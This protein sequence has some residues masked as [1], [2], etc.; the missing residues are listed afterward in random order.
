M[1]GIKLL[2]LNGPGLGDLSDFDGKNYGGLS[3]EG[4]QKE[5]SILCEQLGIQLD[6][7]QTDD[8]IEMFNFIAKDSEAYDALII[9]PV[10]YSRAASVEFEM[11]HSAILT[12]AHLKKPVIEVH[13]TNIFKP[14]AEITKPLQVPEGNMGFI[15]GLGISGY[16]LAIKA[17]NKRLNE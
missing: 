7:R 11:Y 9:N 16:L 5:C 13:I 14:E 3:L 15:S 2:I 6:F 4:I 12:I 17:V 1:T 8:E 10:G